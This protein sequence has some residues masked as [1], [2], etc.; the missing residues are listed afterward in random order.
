MS[1]RE[2]ENRYARQ[3]RKDAHSFTEG[4]K[5]LGGKNKKLLAGIT[6][7]FVGQFGIHKFVLGYQQEGLILLI[8][9]VLGYFFIGIGIG[10][11]WLWIP[12]TIGFI[13]GIVYLM[14][15]D[16]EFYDTYQAGRRPWF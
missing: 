4:I 3:A 12:P 13:E 11:A 16:Q 5:Q 6:A 10:W 1:A 14:K 7:L 9:T 15:S 8:A 2:E